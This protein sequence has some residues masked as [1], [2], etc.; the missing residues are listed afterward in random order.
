MSDLSILLID[1]NAIAYAAMYQPDL[2]HLKSNGKSTAAIHGATSS[3]M[4]AIKRHEEAIPFVLWDGNPQWRK[5]ILPEYKAHR[6]LKKDGSVD[7]EK[8]E[9]KEQVRIQSETIKLLLS[10]MGIPQIKCPD[11]EA[12]DVAG[13][14]TKHL[15]NCSIVMLSPDTDWLQACA[16]TETK[17]VRWESP[18]KPGKLIDTEEMRNPKRDEKGKIILTALKD[19]PFDSPKEY[20][21]LKAV[22]GDTSDGIL[23]CPGLGLKTAKKVLDKFGSFETLW[24]LHEQG[25]TPK[26]KKEATVAASKELIERNIKIMDWD[27]NPPLIEDPALY[28]EYELKRLKDQRES[29]NLDERGLQ[30]AIVAVDK[31]LHLAMYEPEEAV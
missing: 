3:I 9:I 30:R 19:G 7:K 21:T 29:L 24:E 28:D 15:D 13:F 6:V 4:S 25:K 14:I 5:D 26:P 23:G 20:I 27:F 2:A 22:S 31:A 18:R 17:K 11:S 8:M 16:T 1:A 10:D 12:D